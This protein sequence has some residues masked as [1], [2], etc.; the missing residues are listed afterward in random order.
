M[1]QQTTLLCALLLAGAALLASCGESAAQPEDGTA[2]TNDPVPQESETEDG[3]PED[4]VPAK[5][6]GGKT[7]TVLTSSS[8]TQH[9]NVA[10]NTQTGEVLDDALYSRTKAVEEK[11]NITFADDYV[12]GDAGA[13][14]DSFTNSVQAGEDAF[15]LAML[16]ERRAF[17]ITNEGYFLDIAEL[18]NID[19][20]QPWWFSDVN[21]TI[22]P[23]DKTYLSYGSVNLGL[24]DMMHVL[25][26]NKQ[27][28]SSLDLDDPYEMVL[29]GDWTFDKMAEMARAA[30]SDADG[31]GTWGTGDIYG[32]VGGYNT[33]VVDFLAGAR[34]STI[35]V[36][37]K[38]NVEIRLLS[39]PKI[40]EI[41]TKV[42][43]TF[44]DTGFWYTKSQSSNNYYLTDTYFQTDQALFADHTF[45][46]VGLLRDMKSDFGIIPFPKADA[47]QKEYGT[48]AEAGTRT[49]TVPSTVKDTELVGSVLE[50]LNFLS[51]RDVMP[52]YYEVT[53]KQ[54][55][56]RDSISAQMLDIITNA[57]YY[58][59][60]DTMFNDLVKDG[61]FTAIFKVN[62]SDYVSSATK[63][64]TK[65]EKEV[66]KA[67][68]E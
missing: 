61:L 28:V 26:F 42:R 33:T 29:S 65:L 55:Y 8:T 22:N 14:N 17:A 1:K 39:D 46:S 30:R 47:A 13:A 63:T 36:D 49:M 5:D 44:W 11:F 23:T 35:T 64:I 2:A 24:Y 3:T 40:E 37:D 20:S 12:P 43:E 50:T 66:A 25:L 19:L 38:K 4:P 15:D 53:L 32:F 7:F 56:S 68:G 41:Y 57:V 27:M 54:K 62:K 10:Y 51:W 48:L 67:K 9:T 52:A 45:Y 60:G 58:D 16:L 31:D 6:F 21:A 34:V 59:L 18:P